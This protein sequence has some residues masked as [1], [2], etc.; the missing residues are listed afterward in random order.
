MR[1][2]NS[3]ILSSL[4]CCIVCSCGPRNA[5]DT[6]QFTTISLQDS[7]FVGDT[8][9]G[10]LIRSFDIQTATLV[11]GTPW[12]AADLNKL[13]LRAMFNVQLV[14]EYY[15][16]TGDGYTDME[17][18]VGTL[19]G[20]LEEEFAQDLERDVSL[21]GWDPAK[22]F[23]KEAEYHGNIAYRK[24]DLLSYRWKS[25]YIDPDY[26]FPLH[27]STVCCNLKTMT[28]VYLEDI[29]GD[30]QEIWYKELLMD[31]KKLYPDDYWMI[32]EF[33]DQMEIIG[34]EESEVLG[35]FLFEEDGMHFH[36]E[37]VTTETIEYI[38]PWDMISHL[39]TEDF[40][41]LINTRK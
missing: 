1:H 12:D 34:D 22:G 19:A 32:P 35:N 27:V 36:V 8:Y 15:E 38:L 7:C 29:F 23:T 31:I 10:L 11:N 39:F 16:N 14:E 5:Q 17:K 9:H 25:R 18:F 4:I 33:W 37:L 21:F 26:E 28:R 20:V 40:A 30:Q 24:G 3:I 2:I 13:V 6:L 41:A